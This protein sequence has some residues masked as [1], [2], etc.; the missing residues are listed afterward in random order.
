MRIND[1]VIRPHMTEKALA[2]VK[3]GVYGFEVSP[4]ASKD[5]VRQAVEK[6]FSVTISAVTTVMRKGKMRRVG[7]KMKPKQLGNRK[8]AYV[9][10]SKGKIDMFPQE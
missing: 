3:R 9:V 6:L 1:V 10:L 7:R 5:Q 4:K 2:Q 8:F